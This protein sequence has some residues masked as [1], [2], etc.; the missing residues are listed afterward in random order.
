MVAK[1]SKRP[2]K[3]S[4]R[5]KPVP[6]PTKVVYLFGAGATQ[7]EVSYDG[8]GNVSVLMLDTDL[9]D[10]ISTGVLGRLGSEGD[11]FKADKGTDVEKLISL[12]TASGIDKHLEVAEK[13]RQHYFEEICAR[14]VSAI[15][16]ERPTLAIALLEMHRNV[17]FQAEVE[18][19]SGIITTNHDG[20]LQ[21]AFMETFGAVDLG[22]P[23]SSTQLSAANG[24]PTPPLLE[25][26]GSF[27]WS[28][29][30]P[31]EISM[32]SKSSLYSRDASWIPPTVL[33][34]SKHY[35]FNKLTA[36]AYEL[37]S[38]HCDVLRV[39]GSSLTQNDWNILCLIFNAQRH[40]M[41][42]V[43]P[44]FTIELIMPYRDG[45][46]I[47]R[48]ATYLKNILTIRSL[49]QGDFSSYEDWKDEYPPIGDD[50]ANPFFFWLKQ[51]INF[52][53]SMKNFGTKPIGATMSRV[54]GGIS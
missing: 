46:A 51:K 44:A 5:A 7:A 4:R 19:L 21:A 53:Q 29:G 41:F 18:S 30:S 10:G 8:P 45:L 42:L 22:F 14:L 1:T 43:R 6:E 38:K 52:H 16:V 12:L 32:L 25:L 17:T 9:G 36:L 48:N 28:F 20:L 3:R 11:P 49:K 40:N 37:L 34:E 54:A 50:E 24:T 13:M 23:F 27:T 26:H 15:H 39:I 31:L 33:K 47:E 2:A 35:P